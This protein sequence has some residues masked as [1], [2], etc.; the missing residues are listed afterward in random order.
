[1]GDT[2][3]S[4][5]ASQMGGGLRGSVL[6]STQI[7]KAYEHVNN[8]LTHAAPSILCGPTCQTQKKNAELEQLYLKAQKN[9]KT[10]PSELY[11]AK[12]NYYVNI[13]GTAGYN[14]MIKT[15][16]TD[17]V[18][19]IS[20]EKQALF[21]NNIKIATVLTGDYNSLF[22][23]YEYVNELYMD[24]VDKNAE[25]TKSIDS[26]ES[27]VI[28]NDRKSY[29]ET[30]NY[31]YLTHWYYIFIRIYILLVVVFLL[32]V[33]LSPSNLSYLKKFG[34]LLLLL[35]YPFVITYIILFM[36]SISNKIYG[37]LPKNVYA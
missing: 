26:K 12:K 32:A 28:T 1:M 29:Y 21:D 31:D 35:V 36:L 27:D 8:L 23:N 17:E 2:P 10:A 6:G 14:K 37:F 18:D 24:Y 13:D 3:C 19:K 33:F 11:T 25:L 16:Y 22:T 4:Q 15:Q 5:L 34:I 9:V 20:K 30:Q 7:D